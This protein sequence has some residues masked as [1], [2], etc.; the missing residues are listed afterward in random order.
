MK[1][2]K[3]FVATFWVQCPNCLM[4]TT[5]P[6]SDSYIWE[7]AFRRTG[8]LCQCSECHE[9]FELPEVV[10]GNRLEKQA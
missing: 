6:E 2:A 9:W 8:T 1:K 5:E 3:L 4:G 10:A 7:Y